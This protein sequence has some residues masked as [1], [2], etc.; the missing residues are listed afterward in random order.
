LDIHFLDFRTFV[1]FNT[2]NSYFVSRQETMGY[3]PYPVV[4]KWLKDPSSGS[5]PDTTGYD[6]YPVVRKWFK[7]PSSGS[8]PDTTIISGYRIRSQE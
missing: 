4:R 5:G 6:P 3:G 7:D 2:L 1:D 8:G